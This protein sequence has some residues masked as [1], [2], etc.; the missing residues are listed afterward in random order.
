[1]LGGAGAL[2][3]RQ[4]ESPGSRGR[5]LLDHGWLLILATLTGKQGLSLFPWIG[6]EGP[7]EGGCVTVRTEPCSTALAS[8]RLGTAAWGPAAVSGGPS[9]PGRERVRS[10]TRSFPSKGTQR[11]EA[12]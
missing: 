12:I 10:L 4:H 1:M 3:V 11:R 6:R 5:F 9:W 7:V 2:R 8:A